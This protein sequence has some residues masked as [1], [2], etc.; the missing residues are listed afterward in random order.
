MTETNWP[1]TVETTWTPAAFGLYPPVY[2]SPNL[3][4]MEPTEVS[5]S[6]TVEGGW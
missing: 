6:E 4:P 3:Y 1:L 5:W 2:P